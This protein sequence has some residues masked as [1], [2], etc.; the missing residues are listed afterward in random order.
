MEYKSFDKIKYQ[1]EAKAVVESFGLVLLSFSF[2][3]KAKVAFVKVLL[4]SQDA[5]VSLGLDDCAK[6]HRVLQARLEA[7]CAAEGVA[8]EVQMEVSTAGVDHNIKNAAEFELLGGRKIRVWDKT[9]NDW[10]AGKVKTADS[11]NVTLELISSTLKNKA[12]TFN[13]KSD[14][15]AESENATSEG[16]Q[17][18]KVDFSNIAKAKFL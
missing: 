3:K 14:S 12:Q 8:Q 18:Y 17:E 9:C 10:V 7:L 1:K 13:A 2:T 15:L 6:V 16:L 4:S 5:S 11:Q